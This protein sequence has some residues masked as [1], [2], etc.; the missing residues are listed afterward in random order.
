M[1]AIRAL[2][3]VAAAATLCVGHPAAQAT[4]QAPP[5]APTPVFRLFANAVAVD[6]SVRQDG[7]PVTGLTTADFELLDSGV[8][9]T[10]ASSTLE[11]V[12]LDLTLLL[13]TSGST[14]G[15]LLD[16]L[17]QAVVDTVRLLRPDDRLRVLAIQHVIKEVVPLQNASEPI[18]IERLV[19]RG[20][21]ALYDGLAAVLMRPSV[22]GRRQL[23]VAY[24]DGDDASSITAP[25]QVLDIALRADAVVHVVVPAAAA[26]AKAPAPGPPKEATPGARVLSRAEALE[27]ARASTAFPN[28]AALLG[29]TGRTGGRVFS[30]GLD[31][32]ISDA[33][34]DV[35]AD[36]RTSYLLQYMPEGVPADGW[37][38]IVVRVKKP[39]TYEV[40]ARRGWGG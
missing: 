27:L 4:T 32:S 7:R 30:I 36:Y 6:V 24:T 29:V 39:G 34:R 22:M 12:P 23:V 11:A 38:E 2:A 3:V 40:R 13:D 20:G 15:V 35:L 26:P 33:F 18:P 19:A 8:R 9:Q 1:M 5:Q 31:D 21:T 10:I 37:H 17:K 25:S 28:E 16:R 14:E